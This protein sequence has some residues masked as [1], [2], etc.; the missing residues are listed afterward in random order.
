MLTEY[1]VEIS[2]IIKPVDFNKF[3]ESIKEIGLYWLL[4]NQQPKI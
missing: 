3:V 4:L 1:E 2:Y